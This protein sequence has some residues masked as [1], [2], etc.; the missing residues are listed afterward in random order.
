MIKQ[1]NLYI[2]NAHRIDYPLDAT[3]KAAVLAGAIKIE[4]GSVWALGSEAGVGTTW[5]PFAANSVHGYVTI[6]SFL[7]DNLS[8]QGGRDTVSDSGRLVCLHG[9]YRLETDQYVTAAVYA[10]GGFVKGAANANAAYAGGLFTAWDSTSDDPEE[11]MGEVF[12]VPNADAGIFLGV[13][14]K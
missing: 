13:M 2:A 6:S 9:P 11:I 10:V 5:T 1:S 12:Q 4:Q 7:Q 8:G 3:V 14:G